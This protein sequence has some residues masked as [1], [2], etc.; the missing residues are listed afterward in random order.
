[1]VR[2]NI[3]LQGQIRNVFQSDCSVSVWLV[4]KEE[5]NLVLRSADIENS[6]EEDISKMFREFIDDTILKNE[7]LNI[8][9]L[10]ASDQFPDA[11][12]RYDHEIF[13]DSLKII[14]EFDVYEATKLMRFNS[15]K[16]NLS[17][18]FGYII[19]FGNMHSGMILFKKHYPMLLFKR[20]FFLSIAN[21]G[22]RMKKLDEE[23]F[24]RLNEK[25]E[26]VYI[27]GQL[28]V[29]NLST[30][31][32]YFGFAELLRQSAS[33][34]I[35]AIEQLGIVENI[36]DLRVGL[37]DL[38]FV[39]KLAKIKKSSP[40]FELKISGEDIYEFV[41]TNSSLKGKFKL[42][43]DEKKIQLHTKTSKNL[44]LALMNDSFLQ[45]ELTDLHYKASAKDIIPVLESQ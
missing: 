5:D 26:L 2:N 34:S 17:Q 23:L 32:N 36:N 7:D 12:Y 30:L 29:L 8:R 15:K 3:I 39:R 45:S 25:V 16:D 4:L 33:D 1:M 19:Y 38:G 22:D 9:D 42:N 10:M 27:Q 35:D 24:I 11:I 44:F 13:P 41:K 20:A 21:E 28:Y 40:L 14:C 31:E 18:L 43:E 37:E 6:A